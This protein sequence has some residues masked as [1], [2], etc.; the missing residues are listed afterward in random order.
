MR[1]EDY[2][3]NNNGIWGKFLFVS[4]GVGI[5]LLIPI[6]NLY[7]VVFIPLYMAWLL[8][9]ASALVLTPFMYLYTESQMERGVMKALLLLFVNGMA[10]GGIVLYSVLF[11]NCYRPKPA[12]TMVSLR[13]IEYGY[14]SSRSDG[15]G[16]GLPNAYIKYKGHFKRIDL[17]GHRLS[18]TALYRALQLELKQ[19]ALGF[20]IVKSRKLIK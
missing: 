14:T 7:N 3:K 10:F 19:G 11:I 12:V 9:L 20:D 16:K 4:F 5:L 18:D 13:V 15:P 2:R 8:W 17:H 1:L 6:V